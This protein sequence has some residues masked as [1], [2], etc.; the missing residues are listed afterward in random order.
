MIPKIFAT[1]TLKNKPEIVQELRLA[2]ES[3]DPPGVAAATLGMAER[4]DTT[5]LLGKLEIPVLVICGSEDQFSP[6]SEMKPLAEKAKHGTFV[7]IPN[8]GHLPPLEQP[9]KFAAALKEWTLLIEN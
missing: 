4:P 1:N 7:E 8:T 6:P 9:E 3:N 2:I 5:E